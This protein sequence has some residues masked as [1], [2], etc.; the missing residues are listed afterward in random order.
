MNLSTPSQLTT[1]QIRAATPQEDARIAQH[2]YQ[3]WRD[4]QVPA[5]AIAPDWLAITLQ[6]IEQARHSLKYQA[7]V[8]DVDG[9]LAGSVSCQ[10]FAGLYPNVLKLE[11]RQYG[12]IWNVY[13]EPA[14]RQQGIATQLMQ[15]AIAY[16]RDR[17]CT[18]A[19]LHAS[20]AGKPLYTR[21]GF[22]ETNSLR[23]DLV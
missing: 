7:F 1:P 19:F 6:F 16:L 11:Y 18:Q 10:S 13:V 14:H 5:A 2:F 12:Y 21:L 8:A 20:P 4:N 9:A 17:G 23:L 22:T 15:Q 3:M